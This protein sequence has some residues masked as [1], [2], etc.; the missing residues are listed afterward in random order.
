MYACL[1]LIHKVKKWE[2]PGPVHVFW[3]RLYNYAHGV[4][5]NNNNYTHTHG[6]DIIEVRVHYILHTFAF[7]TRH[8][9]KGHK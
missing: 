8:L 4:C 7:K 9:N 5:N 3:A 2:V 1:V 6:Q